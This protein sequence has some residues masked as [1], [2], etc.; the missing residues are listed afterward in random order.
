[1][2][3]KSLL[4]LLVLMPIMVNASPVQINRIWYNLNYQTKEAEVTLEPSNYL[5]SSYS[6]NIIIPPVV[7]YNNE[8]FT[9]TSIGRF[10]FRSGRVTSVI[11]PNSVTFID[12]SAFIECIGLK[13]ITIPN[14]VT[15]ISRQAFQ[16]CTGL[17]SVVIPNSVTSI[18]N[19]AFEGCKELTSITIPNSVTCID[20]CTF[21]NCTALTSITIPNSVTKICS[22]AF[23]ECI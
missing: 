14:S 15:T 22:Y 23:Y 1:M 9:V 16:N 21:S 4:F 6:D 3:K 10:A 18:G 12:V 8:N 5:I 11:I 17:T 19:N 20:T 2:K 13:S 7:S